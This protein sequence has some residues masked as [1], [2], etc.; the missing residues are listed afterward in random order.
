M[1]KQIQYIRSVFNITGLPKTIL[2]EIALCGR[3]NVGK[4]S[5]INSLFNK[6]NIAK[7]SSSPGKT[8]SINYYKVE[9]V[10]YLVDLPG[11]GYAKVSKEERI[12]WNNLIT[13]YFSSGRNIKLAIHFLDSR[14]K[15]TDLDM[16]LNKFLKD[17]SISYI[18]I[19]NKIDKLKQSELALA[20]KEVI[21]FFPELSFGEDLFHYS[22]FNGTGKK[23]MLK[24][25]SNLVE[26][27][28][29]FLI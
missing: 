16:Q 10:F 12:K 13:G 15:P 20:K 3:S 9:E 22:A 26:N 21:S 4:S 17:L 2:P 24:K 14:H 6:K 29:S 1:L 19:L 5:F 8:R 28:E 23:E 18:I 27:S 25:L 11:F 7:T